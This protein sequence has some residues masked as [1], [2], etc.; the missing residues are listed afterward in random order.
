MLK[1]ITMAFTYIEN[2]ARKDAEGGEW[3]LRFAQA[4]QTIVIPGL[5][6]SVA[7]YREQ[8]LQL[9]GS[10]FFWLLGALILLQLILFL[11][12]L[13]A[14]QSVQDLYFHSKDLKKRGDE[15]EQDVGNILRRT[16]LYSF[17]EKYGASCA[18]S[19][20]AYAGQK[21]ETNDDLQRV[22]GN[23]LE[24]LVANGE[25]IFAFGPCEKWNF[26]V[27][28]YSRPQDV[29]IPV[30]RR[31]GESHP[32]QDLGRKWR[33]GQGHVGFAFANN[34][35]IITEDSRNPDVKNLVSASQGY[36]RDYARMYTYPSR[37][38]RLDR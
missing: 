6:A 33:R 14:K 10:F 15:L 28:L 8:I 36:S 22:V 35:P 26:V 38:F 12:S 27:Y 18:S 30:W 34:R 24:P 9:G 19:L 5:I 7:W 37:A 21:L 16:E 25:K 11:L 17:T 29:L 20:L 23:M 32:S 2:A 13:K 31:K 3:L 4:V 1:G